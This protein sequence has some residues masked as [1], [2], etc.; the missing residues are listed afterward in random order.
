MV[1]AA[2]SFTP[3]PVLQAL[4]LLLFLQFRTAVLFTLGLYFLVLLKNCGECCERS[5]S[6]VKAFVIVLV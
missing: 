3:Q 1:V 4:L 2:D 5:R 6:T